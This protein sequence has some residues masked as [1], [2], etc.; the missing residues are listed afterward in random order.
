MVVITTG[1]LAGFSDVAEALRTYTRQPFRAVL[2]FIIE[3]NRLVLEPQGQILDR[4]LKAGIIPVAWLGLAK[5]VI[6]DR[7]FR[8]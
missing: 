5:P 3:E 1:R 8:A 6:P 7:W 2:H 4:G